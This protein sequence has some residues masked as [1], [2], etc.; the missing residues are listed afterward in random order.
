MKPF[1]PNTPMTFDPAIRVRDLE[2]LTAIV[3]ASSG[4]AC[5]K[6]MTVATARL[7]RYCGRAEVRCA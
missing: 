1:A 2:P 7:G 6:P 3:R 4:T 5:S